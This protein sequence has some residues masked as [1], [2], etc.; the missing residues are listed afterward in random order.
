MFAGCFRSAAVL[1]AGLLVCYS[2]SA[3]RVVTGTV[4]DVATGESLPGV[5]V[6]IQ[7]SNYSTV[8]SP[9]GEYTFELPDGTEGIVL[10]FS[11]L[12]Y[13]TSLVQL[14]PGATTL[15]VSLWE[16]VLGLDEVVI[17]G[18]RRLPRLVKD[19]IVPIDVLGPRD[20]ALTTN[21]DLDDVL[22][23]QIPSYNVNRMGGDEAGLVR[24]ATLRGLPTDNVIVLVNGK[25]RHRSSSIALSGSALSRG[26]QGPDLNT[27]PFIALKQVEILRDGAS[28]Q[29]GADAVAGVFNLQLRD[30]PHGVIVRMQGGQYGQ[31]DGRYGHLAANVGLNLT[32][33]GYLSLSL[34]GR[35]VEPT[36]RSSQRADAAI[37]ATRGY[38]V[39][40]PVQIVGSP[41]VSRAWT[42]FANAGLE[43]KENI[44]LYAFGGYSQRTSN[45]GF[46]FRAPGTATARRSVFRFGSGESA[47]RA[48]LDLD[49]NDEI[50]CQQLKDLPDLDS[51]IQEV[52]SFINRYRGRC[53]LFNELFPGG[54]TPRHGSD[55]TDWSGAA[56][57]E[58]DFASGLR[59]D[60][61][62]NMGRS[63]QDYFIYN[64]VNASYGPNTP[65]S[66]RPRG[67]RQ[68]ESEVA[69]AMSYPVTVGGLASPISLAW[70]ASWREEVFESVA[71]NLESYSPGPYAHQGFSVGSNGYQG[72]NPDY[73]G[74]WRRPNLAVYI[75]AEA[76]VTQKWVFSF[77]ARYENY[78]NDF[79][80]AVTGK[81]GGL[82]R[83]T[84]RISLR[85]TV[86]TG[87]RAPT[88]GQANLQVF[89]TL[90]SSSLR[91]IE[92]AQLP[93]THPIA[94]GLGGRQLTEESARNLSIGTVI[95]LTQ[96]MTL[97][98]DYY[99]IVF[100]DRIAVSGN[101]PITD[102][103]Q[104]IQDEAN[105]LG[106][107]GN[108][109]EIRFYSND[110]DTRTRGTDLVLAWQ[111]VWEDDSFSSANLAW[112]W[113]SL[114]LTSFA[115][116]REITEYLGVPL[117]EPVTLSLLTPARRV[118]MQTL[119]PKHRAVF[120]GRHQIG[121]SHGMV[122]LNYY[123]SF[124]VCS[125]G[126]S[127]CEFANGQSALVRFGS[128]L[129][130]AAELGYEIGK[131]YR[132][133]AGINNIFD[134]VHESQPEFL[135]RTGGNVLLELPWDYNGRGMYLRLTADL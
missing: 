132:I 88:P 77:A 99:D 96:D 115:A 74:K 10:R 50:N 106:G 35:D 135:E 57:L 48:V 43:F 53:F 118:E 108:L 71:G 7:G 133:S 125:L 134:Y 25:R 11:Y 89:Q 16:S 120:T 104:R 124:E 9:E 56:G 45:R 70:G 97:T 24:P 102:E 121:P 123:S 92:L 38:P 55:M 122:R 110:F 5:A 34:E 58:G 17:V 83:A 109:K 8:T 22:R 2:A 23:S 116:P 33:R 113:T 119:N 79:G 26:A 68:Q 52:E 4:T 60:V 42:G 39:Q 93:S 47:T 100:K 51:G 80:S 6:F 59:W 87:F 41:K 64:T 112:N 14:E 67:Y 40:N 72:L 127:D 65:T 3:Q 27:I 18:S 85:G 84:D 19:S 49:E 94:M 31:G 111:H 114:D 131:R 32:S 54:F 91:L 66:F 13:R 82:F 128:S 107:I 61:S 21:T 129:I 63:T 12:G 62:L 101:I 73:A 103:I 37:L 75:D 1:A 28:A 69:V 81:V 117:T 36:I 90:T 105:L 30:A 86:S 46:F 126:I 130:V 44:K 95:E 76:D 98:L 15:D 29:Y 20:L 78:Y